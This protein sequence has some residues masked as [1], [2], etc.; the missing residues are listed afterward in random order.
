MKGGVGSWKVIPRGEYAQEP[1]RAQALRREEN[2]A[3]TSARVE[4]GEAAVFTWNSFG[5]SQVGVFG[6]VVGC[7]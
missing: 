2:M 6:N 5:G 1:S 7:C 4:M 3:A